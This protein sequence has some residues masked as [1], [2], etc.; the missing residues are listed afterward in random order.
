MHSY[1]QNIKALGIVVSS[2][3]F[4]KFI[5]TIGYHG[6]QNF[7]PKPNVTFP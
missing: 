3:S 6:N 1:T 7:G 2:F 5:G 4:C